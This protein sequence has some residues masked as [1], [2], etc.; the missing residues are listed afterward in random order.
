MLLIVDGST[1]QR[2]QTERSDSHLRRGVGWNP[3]TSSGE[4]SVSPQISG[5]AAG[6]LISL[7]TRIIF[8]LLDPIHLPSHRRERTPIALPGPLAGPFL[9]PTFVTL[10]STA[11]VQMHG[12]LTIQALDVIEEGQWHQ[13]QGLE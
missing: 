7:D 2:W 11:V 13:V 10:V 8:S 4:G 12:G 9:V 3:W 1:Y 6:E 5:R